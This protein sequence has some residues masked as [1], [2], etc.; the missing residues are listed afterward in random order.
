MNYNNPNLIFTTVPSGKTGWNSPSNIAIVK[1]WGKKGI[2]IPSNPS[3]SFTLNKSMTETTVEF[4]PT[5]NNSNNLEF[6]FDGIK[7]TKFA[8]KTSTFFNRIIDIFP[9]INQLDFKIF[10]KNTFPHSTGIASS[11]SG[12]SALALILCDIEN[13]FFNTFKTKEEFYKKASFVARLGSGSACRSIYGN[14]S[15]WGHFDGINN[16]SDFYASELPFEINPIFKNYRDTII[17]LD[18][19]EKKVSST[20]GHN[21]MNNNPFGQSRISQAKNNFKDLINVLKSGDL[22]YFVRIA[23][24]E[25]LTLHA[26]MMTS[27]PSFILMKPNTISVI[28]RIWEYR[29]ET[30][31]PVCFTLDAGPNIH[32]LYPHENKND[33]IEL[34]ESISSFITEQPIM[35]YMGDGPEKINL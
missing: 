14:A 6:Y 5:S 34:I 17:I 13:Q 21:L 11:A 24:N 30:N 4:I 26:M 10:S 2:Q 28:E 9:F 3:L 31:I 27:K 18:S 20:A 33:V 22:D 23:E 1:Y 19:S 29:K 35:D 32:L 12:M 7:N 16:S 8:E 25:A 15:L